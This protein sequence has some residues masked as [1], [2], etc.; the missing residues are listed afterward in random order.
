MAK[1]HTIHVN[2]RS[3]H[4]DADTLTGSQIKALAKDD[5]VDADWELFIDNH[6]KTPDTPVADG[7]QVTIENGMKFRASPRGDR[8]CST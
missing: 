7:Q 1:R 8:G 4:T 6:G 2:K 3:Y 5:G